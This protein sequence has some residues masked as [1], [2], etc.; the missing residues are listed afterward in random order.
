MQYLAVVTTVASFEEARAMARS[1]VAQKLAA[2]VQISEIES[3]YTW[4]GLVQDD[5]EYRV[6][7]KTTADNYDAVESAIKAMHTYDLPAIHA[8]T[9]D[10]VSAEY[11]EWIATETG[12]PK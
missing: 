3:F 11:G 8:F 6:L 5:R 4:E 1:L 12:D 2:C 7:C 10:R 9:L